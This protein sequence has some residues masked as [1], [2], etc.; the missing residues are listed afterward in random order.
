M[1]NL[2]RAIS[3]IEVSLEGFY[4]L[5]VALVC[6]WIPERIRIAIMNYYTNE[7]LE[8][9]GFT[10]AQK[11][12]S[13]KWSMLIILFLSEKTMRFNEIQRLFPDITHATLTKQLR[14]L[15]DYGIVVRTVYSQIPPKVE[16]SLSD[17][18][19]KLK[20]ILDTVMD[21]GEEYKQFLNKDE[22]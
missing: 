16:Y 2:L 20:P 15:E 14:I 13:G 9:C 11:I 12:L 22:A 6:N 4:A 21:W 5:G 8:K 1:I 3:I 17:I 19:K 18:G 10:N 7:V